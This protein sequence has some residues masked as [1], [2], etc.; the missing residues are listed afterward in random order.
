MLVGNIERSLGPAPSKEETHGSKCTYDRKGQPL[1][2]MEIIRGVRPTQDLWWESTSILDPDNGKAHT[3]RLRIAD[4][5]R[6]LMVRG[7]IGPFFHTQT[8]YRVCE[9]RTGSAT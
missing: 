8:W 3:L 1:K 9:E 5:N 2:G 6:S 4:D 7:Y